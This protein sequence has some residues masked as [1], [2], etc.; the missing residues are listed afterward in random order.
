[1]PALPPATP[2]QVALTADVGTV[3]Q[4]AKDAADACTFKV[5]VLAAAP[6]D[7]DQLTVAEELPETDP[8]SGSVDVK[9]MVPGLA[10]IALNVV[11]IGNILSAGTT[12]RV[13]C[14]A[15][16]ICIVPPARTRIDISLDQRFISR[17]SCK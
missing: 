16:S 6:P 8:R 10:V 11:A 1:V 12:I 13:F 2:V 17:R 14:W 3:P 7:V 9:L 4:L 15:E 5:H